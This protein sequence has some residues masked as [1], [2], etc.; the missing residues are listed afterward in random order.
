MYLILYLTYSKSNFFIRCANYLTILSEAYPTVLVN[1]HDALLGS[2]KGK[3]ATYMSARLFTS[4]YV[5][6]S[7]TFT[8]CFFCVIRKNIIRNF[9]KCELMTLVLLM[10]FA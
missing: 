1:S 9:V 5:K 3:T 4:M 10:D 6:L 7:G 8:M 2:M